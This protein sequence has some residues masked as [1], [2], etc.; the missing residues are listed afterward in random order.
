MQD[1]WSLLNQLALEYSNELTSS[2]IR[3]GDA[4]PFPEPD[5]QSKSTSS[6]AVN[7]VESW[8]QA[9][10]VIDILPH[11]AALW[12]H[13]RETGMFNAAAR[14]LFGFREREIPRGGAW[15]DRVHPQDRSEFSSAIERLYRG[16]DAVRIDYRYYSGVRVE[17]MNVTE[18]MSLYDSGAQ[19][20]FDIWSVYSQGAANTAPSE[21]TEKSASIVCSWA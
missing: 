11:P 16:R 20:S 3:A 21:T 8:L 18:L 10:K 12:T 17:P 13:G 2:S 9:S 4:R 15:M 5:R 14:G 7:L 1:R 6:P 19:Q